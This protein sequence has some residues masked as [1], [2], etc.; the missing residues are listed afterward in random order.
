[1]TNSGGSDVSNT[2]VES[3]AHTEDFFI[4]LIGDLVRGAAHVAGSRRHAQRQ[5]RL[6]L[7]DIHQFVLDAE[8]AIGAID[9]APDHQKILLQLLPFR[10]TDIGTAQGLFGNG[11]FIQRFELTGLVQII[12]DDLGDIVC[13]CGA[14][15]LIGHRH[16][17]NRQR[18]FVADHHAR[19][20]RLRHRLQRKPSQQAGHQDSSHWQTSSG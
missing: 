15:A 1:M 12:T 5:Q 3:T 17:G 16:D 9:N 19:I 13:R 10:E 4:D 20:Q 2:G 6:L 8:I 18:R 7:G 14:G 11:C